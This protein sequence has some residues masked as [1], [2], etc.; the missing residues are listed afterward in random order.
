MRAGGAVLEARG[1]E[2]VNSPQNFQIENMNYCNDV[3]E[4]VLL[5]L[6]LSGFCY[7]LRSACSNEQQVERAAQPLYSTHLGED[8]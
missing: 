3:C 7:V 2:Q 4:I 8:A 1:Q 5:L 6:D